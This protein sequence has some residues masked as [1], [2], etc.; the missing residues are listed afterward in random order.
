V[1][2]LIE[3]PISVLAIVCQFARLYIPRSSLSHLPTEACDWASRTNP[4][5]APIN[6][7]LK[8]GRDHHAFTR[9]RVVAFSCGSY[10]QEQQPARV[11]HVNEAFLVP[12]RW[13]NPVRRS[14]CP[15]F[16]HAARFQRY[17]V[18]GVNGPGTKLRQLCMEE[19]K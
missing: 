10:L 8:T 13:F 18:H 1:R 11:V 3:A 7:C 16:E 15:N 17:S 5:C 4:T 12:R 19:N 2:S 9:S 6:D 14:T